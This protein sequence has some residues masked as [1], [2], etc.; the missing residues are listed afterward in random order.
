MEITEKMALERVKS[1]EDNLMDFKDNIYRIEN[2]ID[3]CKKRN[4]K[5]LLVSMPVTDYF[6]Q[7]LNQEKLKKIERSCNELIK[8]NKNV[9]FLNMFQDKR[10]TNEDFFDADHLHS[11][12]A[13]K[14]SKIV[15][16][17]LIQKNNYEIRKIK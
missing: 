14:S 7:G 15:N 8:E 16:E 3:E 5:V 9:Y 11:D 13:I 1:I 17:Y 6:Y 12:G 2:M 10:F 4:I